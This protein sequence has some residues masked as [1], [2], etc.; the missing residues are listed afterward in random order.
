MALPSAPRCPLLPEMGSAARSPRHPR[1]D[2]RLRQGHFVRAGARGPAPSAACPGPRAQFGHREVSRGKGGWGGEVESRTGRGFQEAEKGRG[3]DGGILRPQRVPI[4]GTCS[5]RAGCRPRGR[6]HGCACACTARRG[7]RRCARGCW[8]VW[9]APCRSSASSW[10]P[11]C[12]CL[13]WGSRLVPPV[14]TRPRLRSRSRAD[15]CPP[16]FAGALRARRPCAARRRRP[17]GTSS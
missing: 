6:G 15:P 8:G 11:T 16:A 1:R 7:C 5:Y 10:T 14:P 17:S 12:A 3:R 13:S 2:Q 4:L 9:L